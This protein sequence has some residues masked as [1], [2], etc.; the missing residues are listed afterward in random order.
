M[1]ELI[2]AML[3]SP[4]GEARVRTTNMSSLREPSQ[5]AVLL[6]KHHALLYH[7]PT[8]MYCFYLPA[9]SKAAEE[10]F[11]PR[12]RTHAFLDPHFNFVFAFFLIFP[13][14]YSHHADEWACADLVMTLYA[15]RTLRVGHDGQGPRV[16]FRIS[17]R[18]GL[19]IKADE[20][21]YPWKCI[22]CIMVKFI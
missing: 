5:V 4:S 11:P 10:M 1:E 8:D 21:Q 9:F 13:P 20:D 15:C 16:R 18:D 22:T 17:G 12:T 6:K 7:H 19:P 3:A 14:Q 2:H